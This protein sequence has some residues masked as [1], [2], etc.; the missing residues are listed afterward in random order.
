MS[1]DVEA[2]KRAAAI[3]AA[4]EIEDGM[5]LGLG[6]GSTVAHLLPAIAAR[7]LRG[8][9]CVATSVATERQAAELGIAVEPFSALT[10]LDLAIDGADQIAPD[11][12]IVKGGGG[13]HTRE[14]IVAAAAERFVVIADASKVVDALVAP[15][16]LELLAYGLPATLAA[17]GADGP[18]AVR[19][20]A[21][22]SP[23]GGVIADYAGDVSDPEALAAR[24]SAT[25]GVIDHGLFPPS[26]TSEVIVAGPDGPVRR[27]L[28]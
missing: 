8:L 13:A 5:R 15:V 22:P 28:A 16:P 23:D 17:L 9:R 6:T 3:A 1:T 4:E 11:G 26:L 10:S 27:A 19:A 14:K 7:N 2:W 20:G 18:T 25:P 24:L 21:P 12:W